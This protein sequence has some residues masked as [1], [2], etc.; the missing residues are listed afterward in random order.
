MT[1]DPS[2]MCLHALL[3]WVWTYNCPDDDEYVGRYDYEIYFENML[4][5]I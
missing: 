4:D 3:P 5:I 2:Y 1:V